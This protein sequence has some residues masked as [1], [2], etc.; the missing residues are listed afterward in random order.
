MNIMVQNT[1][2]TLEDYQSFLQG[3]VNDWNKSDAKATASHYTEDLEYIDP[4]LPEG[5]HGRVRFMKYLKI[6]FRLWPKQQW[7]GKITMPHQKPG[8]FSVSYDFMFAN[9]KKTITGRGIDFIEFEGNLI[10]R[11]HVYL[12]A[13]KWKDWIRES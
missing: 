6:L 3:I 1:E 4:N 10:R 7:D 8:C 2:Y 13:D 5:I 9:D 12:N 11:N